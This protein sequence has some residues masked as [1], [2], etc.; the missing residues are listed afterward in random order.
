MALA[1]GGDTILGTHEVIPGPW[2]SHRQ[3]NTIFGL[4]GA[5]V[6]VGKRTA[7]MIVVETVIHDPNGGTQA[8]L[9]QYLEDI[10][11]RIGTLGD[12]VESG[13]MNR[14][15]PDC[16]FLGFEQQPGM[17]PLPPSGNIISWWTKGRLM[18]RQLSPP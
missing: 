11:A 2:E 17:G 16:E 18:F 12:L 1:H 7:R 14:T 8:Q 5:T 6:L 9:Q 10:D 13:N 4:V 15:F 3:E